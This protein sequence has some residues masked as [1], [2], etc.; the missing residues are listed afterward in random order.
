MQAISGALD[1]MLRNH[2]P[3]PALL[4]DRYW[5]V[6]RTNAS[7]PALFGSMIHLDSFPKPRNLLRLLFDPDALRPCVEDWETVA[8]M[9]L[10]RIRREALGQ[11]IDPKLQAL[12]DELKRFPGTAELTPLGQ[13]DSPVVPITFVRSGERLSYFSLITTVG[14]PQTISAQELRLECMFPLSSDEQSSMP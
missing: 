5:N 9:L 4:L 10:A 11:V 3:Y 8:A 6:L 1:T 7:A 12:I 14:T 2:E 13:P